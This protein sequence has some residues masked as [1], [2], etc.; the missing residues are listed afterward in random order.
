MALLRLTEMKRNAVIVCISL[1]LGLLWPG[2]VVFAQSGDILSARFMLKGQVKLNGKPAEGV[3]LELKKEGKSVRKVVTSKSGKYSLQMSISD[4]NKTNEYIL[5]VSREGVVPKTLN[6][7]TYIPRTDFEANPF[8]QYDFDLE[9]ELL[10]TTVSDI[11]VEFPFGK[12]K[13]YPEEGAYAIDQVYAK[14]MKKEESKMKEDPDKYLRELAEKRS[15][16]DN[17]HKK[18]AADAAARADAE[19]AARQKAEE[20]ARNL[21]RKTEEPVN[22]PTPDPLPEI[23]TVP[24]PAHKD[25]VVAEK[26]K[27]SPKAPAP[28]PTADGFAVIVDRDRAAAAGEAQKAKKKEIE[29]SNRKKSANMAS[30]YETGNSVTSL[31]NAVDEYYK[32]PQ[33]KPKP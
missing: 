16:D 19:N 32:T 13:W 3:L 12:I 22:T 18:D 10:Q 5:S 17:A 24:V 30:K 29:K 11:V 31:L 26:K 7:N 33:T 6:I 4:S 1:F 14:M 20:D 28:V 9:I 25:S 2:L 27:E 8:S 21:A 15:K 23:K